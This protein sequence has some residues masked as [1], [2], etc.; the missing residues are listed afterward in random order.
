MFW[1]LYQNYQIDK[2][3]RSASRAELKAGQSHAYIER[4]EDKVDALAL[5]CQALWEILRDST[6]LSEAELEAKVEE[7][8]L[9]DG[10]K[11]GKISKSVD[12]CEKCGRKT[13][14]R[15]ENCLYCGQATFYSEAFGRRP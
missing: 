4:L 6:D 14:R 3:E 11:D 8:D 1:E 9:R 15:R 7:I 10:R 5:T 2:A 13:S 12:C